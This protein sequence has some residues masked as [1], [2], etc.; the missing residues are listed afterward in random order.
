MK[1]FFLLLLLPGMLSGQVKTNLEIM[2]SLLDSAAS[3]V[4]SESESLKTYSFEAGSTNRLFFNRFIT[5][6]N[7]R[8]LVMIENGSPD[9][10]FV[11]E[12]TSV[13]Y[14]EMFRKGFLGSFYVSRTINLNGNYL[15]MEGNRFKEFSLVYSDS[16]EVDNIP[17]VEN[18]FY[19]FTK[20]VIPP[21]PFFSSILEPV[22]A[23]GTTAAAVILF[24]TV[25][26]R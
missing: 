6:M 8:N 24:F 23:I 4:I 13:R 22:I 1:K 19:P 3:E 18:E 20:G 11:I 9:L 25:R 2:Y 14:G 16:I 12:S 21:E 7:S 17:E 15:F 26:S 5:E 10:Q